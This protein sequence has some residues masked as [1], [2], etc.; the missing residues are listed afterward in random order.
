MHSQ[1]AE[2][3][4]VLLPVLATLAAG[5][6]VTLAFGLAL[7]LPYTTILKTLGGP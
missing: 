5:G 1:Q 7:F 2:L 4:Q 6:V 3:A